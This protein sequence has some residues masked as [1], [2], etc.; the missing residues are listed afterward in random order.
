MVFVNYFPN[1]AFLSYCSY[2]LQLLCRVMFIL[3]TLCLIFVSLTTMLLVCSPIASPDFP[4]FFDFH[5]LAIISG[6]VAI[7]PGRSLLTVSAI[8]SLSSNLTY[9][10]FSHPNVA[11]LP[12]NVIS[13]PNLPSS[14]VLFTIPCT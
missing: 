5:W 14:N 4:A 12:L 10:T 8:Y 7:L 6:Q 11:I 2:F 13:I 3:H 1:F 9:A